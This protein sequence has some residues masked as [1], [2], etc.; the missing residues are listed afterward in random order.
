MEMEMAN[1]RSGA[2]GGINSNKKVSVGVRTGQNAKRAGVEAVGNIGV[3]RGTHST[4]AGDLP[5]KRMP[6]F[7]GDKA[8]A[9]GA[10]PLG[11]AVAAQTVAGPGGSRR[12]MKSGSQQQ[13]GSNPGNPTPV[14]DRDRP[15]TLINEF[16][17]SMPGAE[18]RFK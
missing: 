14:P 11:N 18:G 7:P 8:P 12:V 3:A 1:N 17:R 4:D 15:E 6:L 9:G 16:G 13:Y 10:V 5:L 2:G